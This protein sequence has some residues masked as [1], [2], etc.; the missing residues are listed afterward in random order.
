MKVLTNNISRRNFLK[1]SAAAAAALGLPEWF[2]K[3]GHAHGSVAEKLSSLDKPGIALIGCGGQGRSVCNWARNY[4]HVL[5][6]CDVDEDRLNQAADQFKAPD[7]YKDFREVLERD[8]INVIINATPDH[9]HT[10]INIGA[11]KSGKDVYSEKPLTL[12]VDEGKR[13]VD[14]SR[15]SKRIL[16]TGSQQ[17]SDQ[18]F[19]LAC[20]L[21][22]NGRI[23]KLEYI[24]AGLPTGPREGPFSKQPVPEGL[25]WDYYLGQTPV[26]D[27]NGHNCHWNFRWWYRFAGGQMTDWGAHHN[28]IA[29]WALGMD[30]SG[31]V[32]VDGRSLI[33]MIPGGYTATAK[34][35]V[36][37]TYKNGV[38]L[39]T[40]DEAP[41]GVRF[42]GSDGWIFVS[43]SKLTASKDSLLK[44][45]LPDDAVRLERSNSHLGNFFDCVQSRKQPVCDAEIGH[46]SA[47][48]CHLG[49]I[50]VRLRRSLK[51]NPDKEEFADDD[52]ANTWLSRPMRAPYDYDMI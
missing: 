15:K 44:E 35:R 42:N 13:V 16:Q 31:P 5:A 33:D 48:V 21:V 49:V 23:G 17:R 12:T 14:V 52:E 26:T 51:W 37:F 6:M 10:L 38:K 24:V 22:R 25:D 43:R 36:E 28:D 4:G 1:T 30:R 2:I 39:I 9:W 46:R 19:Q 40:T 32:H 45:P 8:D 29:Q 11:M 47:S 20:E 41:N 18:R 3:E 50:S 7:K 34:F 27:Y